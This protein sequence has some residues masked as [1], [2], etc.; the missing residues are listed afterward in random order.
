MRN[1]NLSISIDTAT[2]WY[3][4]GGEFAEIA[5]KAYTVREMTGSLDTLDAIA[6]QLNGDWQPD[7]SNPSQRKYCVIRFSGM[8]QVVQQTHKY[9]RFAFKR[10]SIARD[11]IANYTDELR[12]EFKLLP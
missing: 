6:R 10:E 8:L 1:I 7:F 9:E 12:R 3:L 11:F 5:K 2:R 4:Q